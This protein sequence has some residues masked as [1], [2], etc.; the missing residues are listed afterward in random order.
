MII[1]S[2]RFYITNFPIINIIRLNDEKIKELEEKIKV[3]LDQRKEKVEKGKK[4]EINVIKL[5]VFWIIE[6]LRKM[7]N[8]SMKT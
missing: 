3:E 4:I 6:E 7:M 1:Y 5:V 8:I 2:F